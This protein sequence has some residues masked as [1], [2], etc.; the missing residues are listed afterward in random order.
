MARRADPARTTFAQR[1][2]RIVRLMSAE[3][4]GREAA[5]LWERAWFAE[6]TRIGIDESAWDY[7]ERGLAWIGEQRSAR[8]VAAL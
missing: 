5:E 7:W 2:G 3:R 1:E 4:L 6:A 8:N